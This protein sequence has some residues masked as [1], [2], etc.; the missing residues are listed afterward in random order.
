MNRMTDTQ[1]YFLGKLKFQ[2]SSDRTT[3]IDDDSIAAKYGAHIMLHCPRDN[4][5]SRR[6]SYVEFYKECQ[7]F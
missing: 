7:A 2:S 6:I 4:S 1:A 5:L 3:W